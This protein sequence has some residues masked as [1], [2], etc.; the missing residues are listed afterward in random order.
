MKAVMY[1]AHGSRRQAANDTFISFIEKVTE[2]SPSGIKTYGFL[3]HAEPSIQQAIATCIQQGA[4]EITVVPIFL[5]PGIHANIDIPT[6]C[7]GYPEVVFHYGK[8]LGVDEIMVDILVSRL[9]ESG[10]SGLEDKTILLVGHGSRLQEATS[11]FLMIASGL[12]VQTKCTVHSA[13]VTTAPYYLE[14]ATKLPEQRI[15]ILPY[16]LFSGG[17]TV[18]IKNELA[19]LSGEFLVCDP[20]GFDEKLIPLLEKRATEVEHGRK[21][22]DYGTA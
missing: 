22:S 15:Y 6:E 21:L 3:E 2:Q 20:V 16:F 10:F 19:K 13:F 17:Y 5:L 12:A 9:K 4:S 14:A 11:E 7:Q 1:I 18:K 8:P